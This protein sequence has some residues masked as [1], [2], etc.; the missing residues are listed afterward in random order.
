[1]KTVNSIS[2][3][4][5]SAYMAIHYPT[6]YNIFSA[7]LTND[8]NCHPK[9]KYLLSECQK[10]IPHFYASRELDQTLYAVLELEQ[11]LGTKIDWVASELTYDDIIIQKKMV[12]NQYNRFCTQFL[13]IIP[14]FQHTYLHYYDGNPVLMNIGFR[15]D[16]PKR[17]KNYKCSNNKNKFAYKCSLFGN[18]RQ[19]WTKEIEWRVENFPLYNNKITN[20]NVLYWANKLNFKFPTVSNCDFCFFH[21]KN[22][23]RNQYNNYP[24]RINWWI[25]F[26]KEIGNTFGNNSMKLYLENFT[27]L[28]ED[29]EEEQ[30]EMC[31][32]TD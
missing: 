5:T 23:N 26:E 27:Y 10:R 18:K 32:C 9:D 1:M 7:V 25:D 4:K 22:Q 21:H 16:E 3:G 24:E 14:I 15:Y 30:E 29:F 13:K 12:P 31:G 11:L 8:V 6:D 19:S 20:D 28:D 2:G 17:V